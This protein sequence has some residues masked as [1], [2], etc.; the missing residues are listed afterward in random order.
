MT[1]TPSISG[2][3]GTIT[4]GTC[5]TGPT[6]ASGQC[7]VIVNSAATGTATVNA[8]GDGRRVGG[9]GSANVAVAT[10]GYGAFTVSNQKTWVDARISITP[11]DVN[12]VGAPHTFTVKVEK[13]PGTGFGAGRRRDDHLDATASARSPAALRPDGPDERAR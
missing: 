10:N 3:S 8:S 9:V 11:T 5:G 7:T 13:N 2:L 12:E 4:G 1:V 6:N